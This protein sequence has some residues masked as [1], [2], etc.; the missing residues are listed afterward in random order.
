MSVVLTVFENDMLQMG[1][2]RR[3][4][5]GDEMSKGFGSEMENTGQLRS[6][7]SYQENPS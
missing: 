7:N 3:A 6:N 5:T 4:A 1:Y 2:L